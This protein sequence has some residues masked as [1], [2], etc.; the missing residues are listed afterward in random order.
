MPA[1]VKSSKGS[2]RKSCRQNNLIQI[3]PLTRQESQSLSGLSFFKASGNILQVNP[4]QHSI[5]FHGIL[6]LE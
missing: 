4:H 3:T 1:K 6:M 5:T 2:L